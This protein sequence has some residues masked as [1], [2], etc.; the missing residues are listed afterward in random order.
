MIIGEERGRTTE[1]YRKCMIVV[2]SLEAV[3]VVLDL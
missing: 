1:R 3:D 2:N